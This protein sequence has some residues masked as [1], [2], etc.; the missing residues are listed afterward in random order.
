MSGSNITEPE[1]QKLN[2]EGHLNRNQI[3]DQLILIEKSLNSD[4]Q[5]TDI[6]MSNI[7]LY[8][9]DLNTQAQQLKSMVANEKDS[10]KRANLYKV[11]NNTLEMCANFEGLYLKAL[12]V[13]YRYRQE[14]INSVHRKF[15]LLEID[16]EQNEIGS[17][18]NKAQLLTFMGK[19]QNTFDKLVKINNNSDN[20]DE[21][22]E[23]TDMEKALK[24]NIDN[25][26]KNSKYSL[27]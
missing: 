2:D 6:R 1:L 13:K 9:S 11:I 22:I 18:L 25:M 4:I 7:Q 27:K 17:E 3:N 12:E 14:F 16:L 8:L 21:N 20:N 26:D 5:N 10:G 19:L 24:E 15:K 23:L